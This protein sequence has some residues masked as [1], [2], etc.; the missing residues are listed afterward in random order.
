M[1]TTTE[2]IRSKRGAGL[3]DGGDAVVGPGDALLDDRDGVAGLR[4]HPLD[5]PGDLAGRALRLLGELADL[6]GDDGEAAAVF[7]GRGRPRSPC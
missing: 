4:L 7:T 1:S 2:P 5:Q 6:L 3:A